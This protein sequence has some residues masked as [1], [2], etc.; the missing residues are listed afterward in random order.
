LASNGISEPAVYQTKSV[1]NAR[2]YGV[3]CTGT[4]DDTTAMQNAIYAACNTGKSRKDADTP[5]F[6]HRQAHEQAECY[7]VLG[8]HGGRRPVS[9]T[10]DYRRSRG[11]G[12][13]NAALLWY[14][15]AG[16]TVLEINQT[17]DS[18]FRNFT[19][20]ANAANY[21]T[22]GAKTGILID[23]VAPVTNIVTNNHFDNIQ[24]V[25]YATNSSFIGI[26]I[27]PTAPGT[28]KRKTLTGSLSLAA[29]AHQPARAL[30]TKE[31]EAQSP[32]MSTYTGTNPAPAIRGL[33]SKQRTSSTLTAG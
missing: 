14:G 27:C 7:E 24:V 11:A 20:F 26:D 25:N 2:D 29:E 10:S 8:N 16:R 32:T 22:A 4:T 6:L 5:E 30:S 33:M 19:V 3:T 23:E 17:R 21:T 28:V 18:A 15:A 12:S 1:L 13:G 31:L 9:G